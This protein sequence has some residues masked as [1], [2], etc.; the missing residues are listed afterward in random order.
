AGEDR[1]GFHHLVEDGE[2]L[3]LLAQVLDDGLDDHVTVG[4]GVEGD[5]TG[6]A[7]DGGV[8][9]RGVELALLHRLAQ[10]AVDLL[11]PLVDDLLADLADDGLVARPRRH[12]GDARPHEAAAEDS[13]FMNLHRFL[14]IFGPALNLSLRGSPAPPPTAA[15]AAGPWPR[16]PETAAAPPIQPL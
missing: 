6:E 1:L 8:A 14:P 4:Q 2:G 7:V 16:A 10:R 15:P 12:L 11:Q 5:G 9:L 3:F 13:H